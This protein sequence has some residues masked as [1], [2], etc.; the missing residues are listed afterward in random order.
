M[1]Q[2]D[3]ATDALKAALRAE[4]QG[5]I[6]ALDAESHREKSRLAVQR[7]LDH[8]LYQ[9]ARTILAYNSF[10][11][12]LSTESLLAACAR[13]GKTLAL[14]RTHSISRRLSVRKITDLSIDTE[15]SRFGFREPKRSAETI[16]VPEVDLVVAPGVAFDLS[17]N[18][19]GRGAGYYD[20]FFANEGFNA[21]A[22][23]L[24]F[25][26]QIIPS[27]PTLPHDRAM[28]F[29]FTEDRTLE[30]KKR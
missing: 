23:A 24:S 26:C 14:P 21:A 20:R 4:V 25:E 3:A 6:S 8:P 7:L 11:L 22:C 10:R 19:L 1:T 28:D 12:E 29:I 30:F 17:G 27:I 13:D 5:R 15:F 9:N 2:P 16:L 18:R